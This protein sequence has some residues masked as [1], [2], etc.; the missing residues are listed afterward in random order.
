MRER[1]GAPRPLAQ[2]VDHDVGGGG[3]E[4]IPLQEACGA[5]RV[6]PQHTDV[7]PLGPLQQVTCP[8]PPATFV[9]LYS[10]LP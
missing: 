6:E 10:V 8:K 5:M 9:R 3:L 4:E 2:A 1:A 7:A